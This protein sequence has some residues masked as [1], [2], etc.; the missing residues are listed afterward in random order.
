MPIFRD[1][2]ATIG[3]VCRNGIEPEMLTVNVIQTRA[4]K[5]TADHEE[6]SN[7]MRDS[8]PEME[9]GIEI[10]TGDV[11]RTEDE[12]VS[13]SVIKTVSEELSLLNVDT[14]TL[15]TKQKECQT[16]ENLVEEVRRKNPEGCKIQ[17][18]CVREISEKFNESISTPT[19]ARKLTEET[20]LEVHGEP[21]PP[22]TAERECLGETTIGNA[23]PVSESL[24]VRCV[25]CDSKPCLKQDAEKSENSPKAVD[26]HCEDDS[27]LHSK[28]LQHHT[29]SNG[30]TDLVVSECAGC[31]GE[32]LKPEKVPVPEENTE[33][34]FAELGNS[35]LWL[36]GEDR[37]HHFRESRRQLVA[38]KLECGGFIP[39]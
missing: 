6:A 17:T 1:A 33:I 22:P 31:I 12:N 18:K 36:L 21:F 24:R 20:T 4:Q 29:L 3:I 27:H 39:I 2:G 34:V 10:I 37:S 19:L 11:I 15:A 8:D 28:T 30:E 26:S 9:E 13:F 7:D 5:Y 16:L 14:K 32:K 35:G 25:G 38:E 23:T